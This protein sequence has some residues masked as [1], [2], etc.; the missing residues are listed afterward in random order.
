MI[1]SKIAH[2]PCPWDGSDESP[3]ARVERAHSYRARSASTGDSPSHPIPLLADF[4]S[5]LLRS[6]EKFFRQFRGT[7]DFHL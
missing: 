5:I 2:G 1:L 6:S 7:L 4:F 3:T